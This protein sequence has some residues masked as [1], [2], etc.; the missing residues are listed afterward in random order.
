MQIKL[1]KTILIASSIYSLLF[2]DNSS[3]QI[4]KEKNS[5][6]KTIVLKENMD[7]NQEKNTQKTI[8]IMINTAVESQFNKI[9]SQIKNLNLKIKTIKENNKFLNSEI[10]ELKADNLLLKTAFAKIIIDMK[11]IKNQQKQIYV[12]KALRVNLRECPSTDCKII[13]VKKYGDLVLIKETHG[14]WGQTINGK[15]IYKTLLKRVY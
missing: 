14:N 10:K 6:I 2:A 15:F 1:L 11:D 9:N 4:L 8:N 13:N 5:S 12:V 7:K 3:K